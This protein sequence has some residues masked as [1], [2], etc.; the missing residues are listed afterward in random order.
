M[1]LY[2]LLVWIVI[3]AVAGWL[4]QKILGKVG[5]FGLIGD[6]VVG[7]AGSVIGGYILGL[8]GASGGGGILMSFLTA[9]VGALG[10]VLV[11]GKL[12]NKS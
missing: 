5:P 10:L 4:A 8:L 3:G 7:I 12:I 1:P 9:L 6:I 11:L 2:A